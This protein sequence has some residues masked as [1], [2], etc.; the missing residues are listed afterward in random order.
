MKC[1]AAGWR[2]VERL[3]ILVA[4]W[5][6]C[7]SPTLHSF[8]LRHRLRPTADGDG[9]WSVVS[10]EFQ[11]RGSGF[12]SH[13]I[14]VSRPH[15]IHHLSYRPEK[16]AAI[17]TFIGTGPACQEEFSIV[18]PE[19]GR[20]AGAGWE[21]ESA[22]SGVRARR[23]HGEHDVRDRLIVRSC[24]LTPARPSSLCREENPPLFSAKPSPCQDLQRF[25]FHPGSIAPI[26]NMPQHT[27]TWL[28]RGST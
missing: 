16:A 23:C 1:Y 9:A 26:H 18:C 20:V 3:V 7:E 19:L 2:L 17:P 27:L 5:A 22:A 28:P 24:R 11:V 14:P 25:L 13:G 10:C 4:P 15:G 21:T 8:G 6:S 12:R